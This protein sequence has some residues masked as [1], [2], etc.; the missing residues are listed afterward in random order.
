MPMPPPHIHPRVVPVQRRSVLGAVA[1]AGAMVVVG[2]ARLTDPVVHGTF[3]NTPPPVPSPDASFVRA[4]DEVATL[5]AM[6]A[7]LVTAGVSWAQGVSAMLDAH[8]AVVTSRD[9]L[10]G[11][12]TPEPW[13]RA[14]V[15]SPSAPSEAGFQQAATAL[16]STPAARAGEADVPGLAMLWGSL[17]VSTTLNGSRAPAPVAGRMPVDVQVLDE[18]A[19]RNVLLAHLHS[20]AQLLELGI[21][22]HQGD[23]RTIYRT[24]LSAVRALVIAQQQLIRGQGADPVG[25]LPGYD[26]PGPTTTVAD[27]AG[28]WTLVEQQVFAACAPVIAASTRSRRQP[29]IT[30]MVAQGRAV[31]AR[32]AGTT[33]FPGWA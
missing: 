21:G 2:C 5:A 13:F 18:A 12:P 11:Q 33:F 4:G 29:A 3:S 15:A 9:P 19:A 31:H 14:T 32:G 20:L 22:A 16:A 1:A 23:A 27:I 7:G 24:R 25:P 17:S 6:A 8:L 26:L 30:D 10:A 28:T